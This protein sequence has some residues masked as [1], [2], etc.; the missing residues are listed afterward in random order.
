MCSFS[1]VTYVH[2]S[3]MPGVTVSITLPSFHENSNGTNNRGDQRHCLLRA[4]QGD[5]PGERVGAW[6]HCLKLV[7][8]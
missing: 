1:I 7:I 5:V 2:D 3:A 4:L 6:L 8:L